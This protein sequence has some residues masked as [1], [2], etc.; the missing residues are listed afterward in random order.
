MAGAAC[1][2]G[3]G[4]RQF[5]PCSSLASLRSQAMQASTSAPHAAALPRRR[6]N[7]ARQW[8]CGA[9]QSPGSGTLCCPLSGS[10][11]KS[12]G[13][14]VAT[15][16]GVVGQG[17]AAVSLNYCTDSLSRRHGNQQACCHH[18]KLLQ[19]FV[20]YACKLES[21]TAFIQPGLVSASCLRVLLNHKLQCG[22]V[23]PCRAGML[24]MEMKCG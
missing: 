1:G 6:R 5:A 23:V 14:Q 13:S 20:S 3:R 15:L 10:Q 4:A 9:E 22:A 19:H 17:L 2:L 21:R 18:A 11:C 16:S 7:T 8:R 24:S 12:M